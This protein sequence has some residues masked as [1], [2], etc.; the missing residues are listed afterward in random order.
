L[1]LDKAAEV[2]GS[3]EFRKIL[4]VSRLGFK[5]KSKDQ[6]IEEANE[7]GID[8]TIEFPTISIDQYN[9]FIIIMLKFHLFFLIRIFLNVKWV[10]KL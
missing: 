2:L 6:F 4:V 10:C 5:K 9:K 3:N 8:K 7:R 1:A